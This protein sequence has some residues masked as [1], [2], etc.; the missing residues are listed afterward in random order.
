MGGQSIKICPNC[1]STEYNGERCG[2]CGFTADRDIRSGLALPA[3]TFLRGNYLVGRVL[4]EGG[5]GITYKAYDSRR[6]QIVALK[7]YAPSGMAGRVNNTA[8]MGVLSKSKEHAYKRGLQR[9]TE[10]VRML[11]SVGYVPAVVQI[12]DSFLENG[13][14]YFTMEYLEGSTLGHIAA[15]AGGK[16][17][18][19][20][21]TDV[22]I[23][24]GEALGIIHRQTGILHRDISPE[25]I[26]I[27]KNGNV[28]LIDFGS[29][30]K[31][32]MDQEQ[33]F[34]VLLKK[35]FA[36]L[37][38]YSSKTPQ[39][40]YT[41]V[42]A[43]AGTYYFILTGKMIPSAMDRA[44]GVPYIPLKQMNIGISDRASD[45]VDAALTMD[46]RIRTQ[47]MEQFVMGIWQDGT[48]RLQ[49]RQAAAKNQK[50][51]SGQKTG[52]P[53]QGNTG[54][55]GGNGQ[56]PAPVP[57][58]LRPYVA[59]ISGPQAGCKWEIRQDVELRLGRMASE[60]NIILTGIPSIS[61]V[62][63]VLS[64]HSQDGL[65]WMMDL[66]TNGT[67][68]LSDGSGPQM[69]V[70]LEKNQWYKLPPGFKVALA[71]KSCIIKLGAE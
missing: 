69:A 59:V 27:L 47:T 36:P 21:V 38:Q 30:K 18:P 68:A 35:G 28:R 2:L 19:Q 55:P 63:C 26:F 11:K 64:Y 51:V 62:H 41:D 71:T 57:R 23:Q 49:N 3:G 45:A 14:G 16:L 46:Y 67:F 53:Q 58:P 65:F 42:Y 1:F 7:E 12:M 9:F 4:G 29:A 61:K 33:D 37:E 25:N 22:I 50:T 20:E 39:G 6:R 13:T 31:M 24:V 34:S 10:E 48:G 54:Q 56:I 60:C 44:S 17:L 66:S 40:S 32:V 15:A 43:L 70:R 5:F 52:A 8:Q